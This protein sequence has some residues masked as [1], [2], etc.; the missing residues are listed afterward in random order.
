[1]EVT[2]ATPPVIKKTPL[3]DS[4]LKHGGKMVDFAGWSMPVQFEGLKAEHFH[5]RSKVGLFDV[6]HMGEIRVRGEKA[7]STLQYLTTNDVQKLKAGQ[8]QYSL[9]PNAQGGII[10]DL[11]VYCL[12]PGLDYL[13][14]VNAAN[15]KKDLQFLLDNN[16]EGAII[17]DESHLWG[18]IAIQGPQAMVYLEKWFGPLMK[19]CP[20][21]EFRPWTFQQKNCFVARTGYTGEDG[22]E[23]FVPWELTEKLWEELLSDTDR[24]RPIGLGA[25]DTLRTEMK[26]PLY[27]QDIDD[28]TSPYEAGL[29]WV[30]K[31]QKGDFLGRS[32][33]LKVKDTGPQK[34]LVGLLIKDAGIARP[35]YKVFSID[36]EE[37]GVVTSGTLSPSLNKAIA[38]AYLQTNNSQVGTEVLVQMRNKML[39]AEVVKT[40]FYK[41]I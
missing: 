28:S 16:K 25:R 31:P 34:K 27:G 29:G 8:A 41:T 19:D 35:G 2:Q 12:T 26:Y 7:L 33:M 17:E 36:S 6:S 30:V 13:L 11:I 21:F 22:V 37:M 1:M 9:F 5:V 10:D 15:Q 38:V 24:A 20:A 14:C 18:Q 23:I 32:E 4:H 3:Y 39:K 40:P